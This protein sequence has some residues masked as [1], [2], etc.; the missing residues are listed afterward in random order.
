[1]AQ[2]EAVYLEHMKELAALDYTRQGYEVPIA[3]I[4]VPGESVTAR[5]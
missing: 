2:L 4:Y 5:R 1:V 3:K